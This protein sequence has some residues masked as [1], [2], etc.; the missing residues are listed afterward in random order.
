MGREERLQGQQHCI[1]WSMAV[2]VTTPISSGHVVNLFVYRS[3]QDQSA[4]GYLQNIPA[5]QE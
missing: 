5:N 3:G 2:D 4:V 1:C